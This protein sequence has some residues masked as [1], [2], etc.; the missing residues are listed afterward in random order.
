MQEK[1]IEKDLLGEIEVPPSVL[2]GAQTRRAILNFP[3]AGEQT[4]GDYHEMIDALMIIKKAAANA[5]LRSG[6]LDRQRVTAIIGAADAVLAGA[7]R[8]QFPIHY[9]HGGGG[10][11]ANMNANEVLANLADESLGGWRGV[12]SKVHPNNHVNLHQSTNDV[13][14]TACHI[15]VIRRWPLL[16]TALRDL[17]QA[18]RG[19]AEQWANVTKLGRTC[20]Q[21][22]VEM[23]FGDMFGAY[24]AFVER[25]RERIAEAVD[26]LH[27][28]NLGG[29]VVGRTDSLP[30][31][32]LEL[33]PEELGKAAG[34]PKYR[35][36]KDLFL[37][38]QSPDDMVAVAS[39]IDLFARGLL[40]IASDFRLLGS[41]PEAG[42]GEIR[43]PAVQPGSSIMPG[44]I[45]PV[46]PEFVIQLCIQASGKCSA[47]AMAL[48]H[49]EL[50]LNVWESL[51]VFN[52]LDSM[53]LMANAARTFQERCIEALEVDVERNK[54]NAETIIPLVTRLMAKHGYSTIS[55]VCKEASG[56]PS[57][58]RILLAKRGL[59]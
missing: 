55:D 52:L 42:L 29:T 18:L 23:T 20:L 34:D 46:V 12:Y 45:N 58:I 11:S 33:I 2:Y 43:L 47:C 35:M 31:S 56:D 4:I 5:N 38:T 17:A 3:L 48:D 49:G 57:R 14:P 53:R 37:A 21:D 6:H 39:A 40:K 26:H 27:E 7:H 15:A 8:D 32:Y 54:R 25:S 50:E 36:A 1:R 59:T 51:I 10:T 24:A 19:K 44:K 28:V 30:A 16:E 13:Y 9:L 41:G 22:A